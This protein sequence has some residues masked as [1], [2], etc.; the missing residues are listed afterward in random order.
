[1]SDYRVASRYAKA[2]FDLS[3]ELKKVDKVYEDMVLVE[4]VCHENKALVTTL[5]NPI[6]RS[7][8]KQRVLLHIFQKKVDESTSAYFRLICKKNR[9]QILQDSSKVFVALYQ[10]YMGIV[11]SSITT[12]TS[13]S[14]ASR[15]EFE[16]I[17][18]KSTGKKVELEEKTDPSLIGGYIL[19]IGD[20]QV[21]DSIK[22]KLNEL[23]RELK[24]VNK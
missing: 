21:D 14:E 7:D 13:L 24:G 22:T 16:S 20:R 6:V 15:K 5:K 8:Y 10:D 18:A 12:A 19:R 2:L 3:L 1:M 4:K 17:I 11:Q 9:A 23:K